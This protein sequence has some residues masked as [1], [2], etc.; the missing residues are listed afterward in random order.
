MRKNRAALAA[1]ALLALPVLAAEP[2]ARIT[3][4]RWPYT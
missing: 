4:I 1:L 3:L 2:K